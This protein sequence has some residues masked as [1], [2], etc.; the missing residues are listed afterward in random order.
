MAGAGLLYLDVDGP[1]NPYAARAHRRP[2]G[3]GTFRRT[4]RGGWYGGRDAKRY[5]G[6]RVWLHPGHGA[7]LGDLA[8][9]TGLELVWATSWGHEAN[10]HIGP[11]VGLPP[12]PVVEFPECDLDPVDGWSADGGWKWPAVLDHAAGRPLAWF[13]DE[14]DAFAAGRA[15]FDLGRAGAPTLLCHVDPR[16]GLLAEHLERVEDWAAGPRTT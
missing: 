14:H 13:D 9:R 12:L 11:A 5:K 3:Y 1:L 15:A 6:V 10:R 8:A 16:T 7:L 2:E 4:A